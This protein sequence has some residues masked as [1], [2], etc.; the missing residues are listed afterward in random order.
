MNSAEVPPHADLSRYLFAFVW[1]VPRGRWP[2][3]PLLS[4]DCWWK[5]PVGSPVLAH[6]PSVIPL[7]VEMIW[8]LLIS[9]SR[10][11][12]CRCCCCYR[13]SAND[14]LSGTSADEPAAS[15]TAPL[16]LEA[17]ASPPIAHLPL[18]PHPAV[19]P[20]LPPP[21]L[22]FSPLRLVAVFCL[23]S[24]LRVICS[25][26]CRCRRLLRPP[27]ALPF[28]FCGKTCLQKKG[29]KN[30]LCCDLEKVFFRTDLAPPGRFCFLFPHIPF[31]F[32][33]LCWSQPQK[34]FSPGFNVSAAEHT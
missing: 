9:A 24:L 2:L 28:C 16:G 10:L 30:E 17:A 22:L 20:P 4:P 8:L 26:S 31:S 15:Q 32:C 6:V 25:C 14:E 13:L 7:L 1:F 21:P 33:I 23:A 29:E 34:C 12:C 5:L 3:L 11:C 19:S 27:A 18:T